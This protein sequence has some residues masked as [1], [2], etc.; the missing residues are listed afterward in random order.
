[1]IAAMVFLGIQLFT[2]PNRE[3]ADKRTSAEIYAEMQNMNR[4]LRDVSFSHEMR[5]YESKLRQEAKGKPEEEK[6]VDTKVLGAYVLYADTA[7]KSGLYREQ[8]LK[9]GKTQ[10]NNAYTKV[11]R[12][13]DQ[14][15]PKF[16]KYNKNS[17]W[18]ELKVEVY[19]T[20]G[21]PDTVVTPNKIY[22]DMVATLSPMAENDKVWGIVPGY[23]LIDAL[24]NLT[25]A[26]PWF[27]YTFAA[28]LLAIV[29]R[30]IIW[31]DRKSVV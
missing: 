15:K 19:P 20:E 16:E 1:M 3:N 12:A 13:Y 24:V 31:P 17:V 2:A 6:Q 14:I 4:D 10:L 29:V 23:Q 21:R 9:D 30:A 26:Q 27:S 28:L 11:N 22:T 18:Q 25:G 7:L 8:L 5:A